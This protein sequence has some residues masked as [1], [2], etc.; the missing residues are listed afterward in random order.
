MH[1][2]SSATDLGQTAMWWSVPDSHLPPPKSAIWIEDGI[3]W[4]L[5]DLNSS[6]VLADIIDTTLYA[7]H[8]ILQG[9]GQCTGNTYQFRSAKPYAY[10]NTWRDAYRWS[11]CRAR[12]KRAFCLSILLRMSLISFWSNGH[13]S[14]LR[15]FF[16]PSTGANLAARVSN[17]ALNCSRGPFG[18]ASACNFIFHES[19]C[20]TSSAWSFRINNMP[21]TFDSSLRI[22]WRSFTSEILCNRSSHLDHSNDAGCDAKF[23]H[24]DFS[25]MQSRI[26]KIAQARS[27]VGNV[28]P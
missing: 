4:L 22:F 6:H 23:C 18:I 15:S 11:F 5:T 17:A 16:V 25:V 24:L 13:L 12:L 27:F 20:S 2:C 3:A 9:L 26:S 10:V 28:S 7:H 19:S 14:D 21:V 1:Y 8:I